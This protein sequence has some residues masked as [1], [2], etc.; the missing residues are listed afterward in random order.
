MR[1]SRYNH[2]SAHL[3][4][5]ATLLCLTLLGCQ[6]KV[7]PEPQPDIEN[8]KVLILYSDGHNNLNA[9]LNQ[10][11]REFINS[12][13]IPQKHGDVV[14]VYTHPTVSG[15][16]PSK[17][18]LLRAYRRA[19]NTCCTDTLL[20]FPEEIVSADTRTLYSVLLYARSA[21]PAKEYGLVVSTHG[22][23]Y[24]PYNYY[25]G[26]SK[27][28][29][30]D[31]FTIFSAI[32]RTIG[33]DR[34]DNVTYK[35]TYEMDIRDFAESIPYKLK[36]MV[37]DACLM[38]GVEVAY[39]LRDK[40]DYLIASQ[41]E[42]LSD[43]M[44]YTTMAGY[45]LKGDYDGFCENYFAFYDKRTG[46]NRSASISLIDC[47][48]LPA[49]GSVCAGIFSKY[50]EGLGAI[51]KSRVQQYFTYNYH[52]FYDFLD[53]VKES[54]CNEFELNAVTEALDDCVLYKAATPTFLASSASSPYPGFVLERHS[55]LSMYLPCNGG[56][57][58]NSYYRTLD[59]N[60]VTGL[61]G[62]E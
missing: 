39:Q 38:G 6:E 29:N 34:E 33:A 23:G 9:S 18:Y 54:G 12:E 22:T 62:S 35:V 37:F 31:D 55:G 24:L 32:K 41:T 27:Y 46:S 14:L 25:S 13:G 61:V 57:Y 21:F 5:A 43:G 4:A 58:L 8:R 44:D 56:N 2:T 30:N 26:S 11:I 3:T 1:H 19:D 7:Q 45:L 42:I 49:L 48:V 20:T 10:D 28:E 36:Y 51:D 17:S 53:I 47:S 59:W 16:S 52:W 60:K 40:T 50:R 15:Y